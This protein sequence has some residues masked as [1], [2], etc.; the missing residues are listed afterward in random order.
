VIP[1]YPQYTNTKTSLSVAEFCTQAD[2]VNGAVSA[3]DIK[4]SNLIMTDRIY[5]SKVHSVTDSFWSETNILSDSQSSPWEWKPFTSA[6]FPEEGYEDHEALQTTAVSSKNPGAESEKTA[7]FGDSTAHNVVVAEACEWAEQIPTISWTCAPYAI[8]TTFDVLEYSGTASSTPPSEPVWMCDFAAFDDKLQC[9]LLGFVFDGE[10]AD[11]IMDQI[12]WLDSQQAS[13]LLV[14]ENRR[15]VHRFLAK[16]SVEGW[17]DDG[18]DV[19]QFKR[20]PNLWAV[21]SEIAEE[22][23][24]FSDTV[25]VSRKQLI[26]DIL[27]P[28]TIVDTNSGGSE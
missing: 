28:E 25:I 21:T 13:G 1:G 17:I 20:R 9:S 26:D 12:R 7:V 14:M 10:S 24:V 11:E 4:D 8:S 15:A 2:G 18:I 5:R 23:N 19:N 3:S 16:A 6:V 22:S 27:D